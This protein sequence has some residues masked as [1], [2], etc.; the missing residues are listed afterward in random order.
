MLTD[1][2]KVK[3]IVSRV[4]IILSCYF[5]LGYIFVSSIAHGWVLDSRGFWLSVLL[6]LMA[7]TFAFFALR[8]AIWAGPSFF[9][10]LIIAIWLPPWV[11]C[12]M[13]EMIIVSCSAVI[14][15]F[16]WVLLL[17]QRRD[18]WS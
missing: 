17:K 16:I 11:I 10:C 12:P 1:R 5:V 4:I 18:K 13:K 14:C 2:P 7:V 8:C 6:L 15:A 9:G 3:R